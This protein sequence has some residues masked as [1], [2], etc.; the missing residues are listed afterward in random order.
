MW[1]VLFHGLGSQTKSSRGRKLS[2]SILLSISRLQMQHDHNPSAVRLPL[3]SGLYSLK[4][5]LKQ[6]QILSYIDF[7]RDFII[8]TSPV[9]Q[10][11][12]QMLIL[13]V[14]ENIQH[15]QW[16]WLILAQSYRLWRWMFLLQTF[17]TL[18]PHHDHDHV[19]SSFTQISFILWATTPPFHLQTCIKSSTPSIL[20]LEETL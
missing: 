10:L 14:A 3:Y 11:S 13:T 5:K 1:A 19:F 20:P 2:T 12:L 17:P 7:N 8:A 6:I 4:C 18:S 16:D 9:I 15:G